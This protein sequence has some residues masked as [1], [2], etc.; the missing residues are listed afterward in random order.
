[1]PVE[2][3]ACCLESLYDE[4]FADRMLYGFSH[5]DSGAALRMPVFVYKFGLA[6][7]A[8][9][10]PGF[11]ISNSG[12]GKLRVSGALFLDGDLSGTCCQRK[13]FAEN[14]G[15]IFNYYEYQP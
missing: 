11:M 5:C 10:P 6:G 7:P 15:D 2:L 8:G 9:F 13:C 4:G 1:L 3:A 12:P 14:T